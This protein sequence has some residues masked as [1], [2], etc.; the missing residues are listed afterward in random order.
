VNRSIRPPAVRKLAVA[1]VIFCESRFEFHAARIPD[2]LWDTNRGPPESQSVGLVQAIQ[3]SAPMVRRFFARYLAGE[4]RPMLRLAIPIVLAELGWMTMGIVDTIMVGHQR[5]SAVAI[6]AVSLSSILYYVVAIFGT[7]LMLGLDTLVSQSYGAGDLEDTHRSLINGV[8]LSLGLT[9][10]L[11]GLI[12]LWEP[13]V[14]LLQIPHPLTAEAIPYLRALNW[15]TLPLLLYF[16]FRRYLQGVNLVKP[17]MFSL[18][19]ANLVNF[20]GNWAFIY[21]H[22]GFRAMGTVGSGWSTCVARAYMALVLMIYA[23]Y[24]DL[25]HKTGLRRVSR[26]PHFPRVRELLALGF[27]AASQIGVEIGVFAVATTLIGKLGALPLASHQIALNTVSFTYMVPLGISSAAA[28]RVGQALGRR[29][30]QGASRAGWTAVTLGA[31]FMAC[32]ALVLWLA[33]S[34]IARIYTPDPAVI[35]AASVLLMIGAFFQ[36]FD[37]FQAVATGALRGAGD[38]RTPLLC[39]LVYYWAVGLPLGAYLCFHDG[40]GPGGLWAGFCIALIL[41]GI[42]LLYAWRRKERGFAR[43]FDELSTVPGP[44]LQASSTELR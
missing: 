39:H 13:V 32:M 17:V 34:Y 2:R 43:L 18:I 1:I 19:S 36:L 42:T 22:W 40:W 9:P 30:S 44:A 37:G 6:G 27:P 29:D 25:R 14:K 15:G 10:V 38:T 33:P 20:V 16:A 23:L 41:I 24:Y 28:V 3:R 7:G 12:W 5:D 26:R 35:R 21:G 8:Y 4:I 31:S 11:M